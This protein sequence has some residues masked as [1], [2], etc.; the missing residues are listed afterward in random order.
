MY[1]WGWNTTECWGLSLGKHGSP[2]NVA[3]GEL[4]SMGYISRRFQKGAQGKGNRRKKVG[5]MV[6]SGS[7]YSVPGPP[8]KTVPSWHYSILSIILAH[9]LCV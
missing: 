9:L 3:E 7:V 5:V 4:V 8:F 2:W 1:I 6:G